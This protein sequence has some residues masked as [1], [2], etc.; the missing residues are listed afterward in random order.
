[1]PEKIDWSKVSD[2]EF[3]ELCYDI[4]EKSGFVNLTW[5]GRKGKDRGRDIIAYKQRKE[6]RQVHMEKWLV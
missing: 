1:M 3:E 2:K 4:L 5:I 6:L